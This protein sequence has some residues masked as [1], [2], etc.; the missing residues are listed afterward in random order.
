MLAKYGIDISKRIL[1]NHYN[2]FWIE[3]LLA[4]EMWKNH[5]HLKYYSC[6]IYPYRKKTR[7][8]E[9][10][11]KTKQNKQKR[12]IGY[13]I[14]LFL[15]LSNVEA[16]ISLMGKVGHNEVIVIESSFR[17][18]FTVFMDNHR[19]WRFPLNQS[20]PSPTYTP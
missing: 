3:N 10:G 14:F 17:I 15:S 20:P 7:S 11:E 18:L 1:I 8:S 2:Q 4:T 5:K 6:N 9:R 13:S 19:T 12:A 16:T